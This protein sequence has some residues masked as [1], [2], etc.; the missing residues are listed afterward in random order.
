[1]I[2]LQTKKLAEI[3]N[4][5]LIGDGNAVVEA[6]STDTR[7]PTQKGL[8]FAL[9]GEKFDAHDYLPSAVEQGNAA[10]V[11]EHACE[12]DVPQIVVADTRLALGRLAQWLKAE[13]KPLTV[14]MTGSSG[15]TTVKEMT[16]SILQRTARK[17]AVK[18]RE[19]FFNDNGGHEQT[20]SA[21]AVLFT[22]GNFNNDIGVPLTLLRLEPKHRF[23]VI[24]LGANHAGEIDYTTKL[25]RPDVALINNI[26]PA[27]L[28]G[29]GSLDGVARAKGEIYRGLAEDGIA[30]VNLDCHYLP[31]WGKE[32][33]GRQVRSF[34]VA[35]DRA[36]YWA[37][38]V[39]MTESGSA[40]TLHSPAGSIDINL[41]YLG[42]HNIGNALAATALAMSVGAELA[43]VKAGLEQR[44]LVKGRL[45]PIEPCKNL[46]LLDD[47][48]NANV[49]SLK[50]AIDVLKN[51]KAFRILAVGDMAELG[52]N[53][54]ECHQQVADYAKAANLDCVASFGRK[55]A[56]I[57]QACRGI[58][59]TD[60]TGM[61]HYLAELIDDK[62]KNNQQVVVLAKG[63]RS[64]KMEDVIAI[65]KQKFEG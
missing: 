50:S 2:R 61:A 10:V 35:N 7:Q 3:L 41:P 58:H 5:R 53:S 25:V 13:L 40:F 44:S 24:E 9:K 16:A 15:K 28:E 12:I 36:D 64:Q 32:I 11:V 51:Y 57:A 59:F 60:K 46:L 52:E 56:V 42:A 18:N 4:G 27:H 37:D 26:A 21:D 20:D 34:S 54:R 6:V 55:S 62:L 31:L 38:N 39:R 17:S 65:L 49:D 63:S 1:M 43:D 23:A 48:Y 8:F 30:V 22:Q 14:A 45:F 33:G 47:T 29:F 19:V